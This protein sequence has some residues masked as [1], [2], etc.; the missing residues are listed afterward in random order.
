MA[1]RPAPLDLSEESDA[2]RSAY[3]RGTFGQGCLMAR[4]LVEQGVAFVEVTLGSI[5]GGSSWDTH[6]ANFTT[7][8]QLSGELDKAWST[9]LTE[10]NQRGLLETTTVLWL[11]EFGRTPKINGNAGRDH[12]PGAWSCVFAGGGIR[13]GQAYGKTT[14]DGMSV[15]SGKVDVGDILATLA[16][17]ARRRAD[18]G[19]HYVDGA[20]DQGR[21]GNAHPRHPGIRSCPC[22]QMSDC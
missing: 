2:V 5:G 16:R 14:P 15:A 3:G 21:R 20:T 11:G 17:I 12:F 9:L 22:G 1:R 13:G 18:H 6:A 8:K 4:R 10:L 7:V 19:K